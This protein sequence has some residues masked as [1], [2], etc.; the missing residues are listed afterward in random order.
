MMK[1]AST[2]EMLVNVYQTIQY[3]IPEDSHLMLFCVSQLTQGMNPGV[4][5]SGVPYSADQFL[6]QKDVQHPATWKHSSQVLQFS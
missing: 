6:F 2:S 5:A 4:S 1:A 3:I